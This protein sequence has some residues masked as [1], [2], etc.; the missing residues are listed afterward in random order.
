MPHRRLDQTNYNHSDSEIVTDVNNSETY[1]RNV[2]PT[3]VLNTKVTKAIIT[4]ANIMYSSEEAPFC[5]FLGVAFLIRAT[6]ALSSF[7]TDY[8]WLTVVNRISNHQATNS[9]PNIDQVIQC[10]LDHLYTLMVSTYC[11]LDSPKVAKS[12]KEK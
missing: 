5:C 4:A 1:V 6:A 7:I 12:C 3:S 2:S 10:D 8:L 9:P 11:N